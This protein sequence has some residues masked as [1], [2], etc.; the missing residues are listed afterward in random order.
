MVYAP[1]TEAE[2]DTV[3]KIV[4]AAAWWVGGV[5]VDEKFGVEEEET[6]SE[7]EKEEQAREGLNTQA[8]QVPA[9]MRRA[10]S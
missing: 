2:V 1:R 4:A 7:A 5:D 8:C 10:A 9:Y 6:I 3:R